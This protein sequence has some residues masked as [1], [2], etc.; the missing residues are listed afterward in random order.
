MG[1]TN[2]D[3]LTRGTIFAR[4]NPNGASVTGTTLT[5]TQGTAVIGDSVTL[6]C[7]GTSWR[8]I[9]QIGIFAAS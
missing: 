5:N 8:A 1:V 6:V 3:S 7:D 4:A 2:Y 9:S